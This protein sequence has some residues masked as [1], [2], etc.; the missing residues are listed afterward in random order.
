MPTYQSDYGLVMRTF[1][2]LALTVLALGAKPA[3]ALDIYGV[4]LKLG[5]RGEVGGNWLPNPTDISGGDRV[6]PYDTFVGVGGGFG[7]ALQFRAMD[8]VGIE[9]SWLRSF[10]SA[11]AIIPIEGVNAVACQPGQS[12][13]TAEVGATLSHQA[14]H[15]P[16]LLQLTLPAGLARPFVNIGMDFVVKR[17]ARD[18]ELT[19]RDTWPENLDPIE[20]SSLIDAWNSSD[21]ARYLFAGDVN[22]ERTGTY[23]GIVGGIG[24]NITIKNIEIPIELRTTWYPIIGES[25]HERG[26][27][28][29]NESEYDPRFAARYNDYWFLQG[30]LMIGFDYVIF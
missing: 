30:M 21:E 29:T 12:C 24:V 8:I 3:N 27:F 5:L 1:L 25:V 19:E 10:D 9:L 6:R 28:A 13:P 11:T 17:H 23:A 20:D 4:D 26:I 7:L 16:I 15:I 18:L 2:A 14:D 22:R